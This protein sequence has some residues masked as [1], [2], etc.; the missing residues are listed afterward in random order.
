MNDQLADLLA[1]DTAYCRYYGNDVFSLG[2]D[3][4][5]TTFKVLKIH[6][7]FMSAQTNSE[8]QQNI[9]NQGE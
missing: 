8:D 6:W 9:L 3:T 7:Q 2:R 4:Q 5:S 1:D